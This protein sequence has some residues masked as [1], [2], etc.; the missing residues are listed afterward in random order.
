MKTKR[1]ALNTLSET[2]KLAKILASELSS[3]GRIYLTGDLG[4]G[5]TTFV[6]FFMRSIGYLN[7]VT[8]PTFNIVKLYEVDGKNIYHIDAYRLSGVRNVFDLEDALYSEDVIVFVEWPEMIKQ[9]LN[10]DA[11]SMTF[12][13]ENGVH[14][15]RAHSESENYSSILTKIE[16]AF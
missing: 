3:H 1:I 9:F 12:S 16:E 6:Q 5:K 11:L 14:Y 15:F 4:S 10:L 7:K 2:E 13:L 8:S